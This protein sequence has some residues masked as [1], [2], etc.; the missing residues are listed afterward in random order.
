M[1]KINNFNDFINET[2]IYIDEYDEDSSS[3]EEK[4]NI[5]NEALLAFKTGNIRR[6]RELLDQGADPHY[7]NENGWSIYKNIFWDIK[8]TETL[9]EGL[10]ILI[11]YNVKLKEDILYKLSGA[12][13]SILRYFLKNRKDYKNYINYVTNGSRKE[14][15]LH[16]FSRD[17]FVLSK[18]KLFIDYGIDTTIQNSNGETFLDV[19]KSYGRIEKA[20]QIIQYMKDTDKWDKYIKN[21][22][23]NKFNL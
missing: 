6:T 14:T 15:I 18:I 4:S 1:R 20:A 23:R 2:I 12:K 9:K 22:K 11:D 8:D 5:D 17:R 19:L 10:K 16:Y 7:Q 21:Q 13:I 3:M